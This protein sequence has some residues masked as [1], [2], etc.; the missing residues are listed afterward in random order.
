[1]SELLPWQ[2]AQWQQLWQRQRTNRLPH[3]LLC[4]GTAGLGKLL[5]SERLAQ[6]LLCESRDEQANPCE[7]CR[8]C[9]LFLSGGHPDYN[10]AEPGESNKPIKVD[11]VRKL[12]AFLGYTSQFGGYKVALVASAE[13]LTVNAANSL[14]KTLEE[15]P[16]NSLLLLVTPFPS[17]LPATV[18]SRCQAVT[19]SEPPTEQALAWLAPYLKH[20]ADSRLLLNLSAGAPLKALDYAADDCLSRRQALFQC[21]SHVLDGHIDPVAAAETWST[22]DVAENLHWLIGWHMDMIRLKMAVNPPCLLNPDWRSQLQILAERSPVRLLFKRL[23]TALKLQT[24]CAKPVNPKL[25]LEAFL[26]SCANTM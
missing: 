21:Y 24:L 19:F 5:F 10:T 12:C 13:L 9:R 23:D 16:A 15:P 25:M 26:A 14:L 8:S 22:G 18:R 7:S 2:S 1:M 6:A 3:A 4:V 20:S 11:Q 17:R